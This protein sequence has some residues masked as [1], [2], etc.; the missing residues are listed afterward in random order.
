MRIGIVGS[1]GYISS[2]LIEYLLKKNPSAEI[3]KFD[4]VGNYDFFIDLNQPTNFDYSVLSGIDFIIF[5]AAI[6]GPDK[7][8]SD[9]EQCWNINVVGTEHFIT[10]AIERGCK[11]LFF[12]SDAVFGEDL[13]VVFDE[14]SKTNA[15]TAYGRMKK[16]VED[17]FR[18]KLNFKAI[19]LSYV[20]SKKDRFTSYCLSC[21]D[22]KS[23]AEVFHPFYRN[24]IV[25]S[26][27][28][29]TVNWLINNWTLL[30]SQFLN[31]AG[32]ELVS[33][34]RMADEINRYCGYRLKYKLIIP[35]N[36]FFANRPRITQM[37]SLYLY[38]FNIIK[39][40]SFSIKFKRELEEQ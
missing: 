5:T 32:T 22:N 6:S 7:C 1:S 35:D 14:L 30:D 4:Q 29:E 25:I 17:T 39:N 20:A 21:V 10:S 9:F 27:V 12:S 36:S 33:R 28:L 24:A 26:D 16:H 8:A 15:T 3:V 13:G 34:I 2:F 38:K 11:V 40:E 37:S 31:I 18:G 23:E 19:R